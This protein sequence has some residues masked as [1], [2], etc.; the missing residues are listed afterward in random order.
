MTISAES[1]AQSHVRIPSSAEEA[2]V[3]AQDLAVAWS[4][5]AASLDGE[6]RI[7]VAELQALSRSGLLAI[8][9]SRTL[10]GAGVS[11][12]TLSEVFLTLAAVDASLAQVPQNHSDSI[13]TLLVAEPATRVFF[14][15]EV[16]RGAG[17]GNAIAEPGCPS[18][19]ETA[20]TIV[21]AHSL[22]IP[23]AGDRS[24]S[25]ISM[26]IPTCRLT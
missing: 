17:F 13:D 7:P 21:E 24:T 26:S 25:A 6:R 22:M 12:E 8:T 2:I 10:G 5:S 16:L 14:Y 15:G 3:A 4:S 20:A 11:L 23:F 18:R 19:R 9:V 1:V